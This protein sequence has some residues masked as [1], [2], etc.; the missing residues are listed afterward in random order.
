MPYL[1]RCSMDTGML[2]RQLERALNDR[3]SL[4]Y[5]RALSSTIQFHSSSLFPL[6][7]WQVQLS[8]GSTHVYALKQVNGLQMA[9]SEADGLLML[10]THGARTPALVGVLSASDDAAEGPGIRKEMKKE[11]GLEG[12]ADRPGV[13]YLAMQFIEHRPVDRLRAKEDLLG[14]LQRLYSFSAEA[15]GYRRSNYVGSLKQR[16]GLHATFEDFWWQDRIQPM[17]ALCQSMGRLRGFTEKRIEQAIHRC[18]E[19]LNLASERPTPVHGDLWSGNVLFSGS[20]AYLIDPSVAHSLPE[21]DFAMLELFGSPLTMDDYRSLRNI[22]VHLL[23]RR[24]EFFQLYPLLVHVALFG[25]SY[26]RQTLQL[27]DKISNV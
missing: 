26:E 6:F 1:Y 7:R 15:F 11:M 21:Q 10:A 14:S 24:I 25:G 8:D 12:D 20:E 23:K 17:L 16:N 18:I 2:E 27:I 13:Y 19:R 22:P 9:L 3:N 4:P 5:L